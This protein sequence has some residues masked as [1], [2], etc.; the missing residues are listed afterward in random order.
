MDKEFVHSAPK[1]VLVY[2][3]RILLKFL[4]ANSR[5]IFIHL[6]KFEQICKRV[7]DES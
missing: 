1:Y 5:Y 4:I 6:L 2:Y 7:V 3:G